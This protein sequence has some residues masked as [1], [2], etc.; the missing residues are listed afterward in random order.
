M[1]EEQY[2]EGLL[3]LA[4]GAIKF[5]KRSGIVST[6]LALAGNPV[7]ARAAKAVG[8]GKKPKRKPMGGMGRKPKR[9]SGRGAALVNEV[10]L[11]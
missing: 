10:K 4:K 7:A 11:R 3:D 2:G 9:M 5:A 1:S 8:L 6:G